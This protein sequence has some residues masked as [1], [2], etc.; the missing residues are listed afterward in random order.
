MAPSP[1]VCIEYMHA[2]PWYCNIQFTRYL[3]EYSVPV[4]EYGYL[5]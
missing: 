1:C 5:A 3:L 2:I 4:L